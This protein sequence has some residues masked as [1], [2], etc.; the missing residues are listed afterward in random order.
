MQISLYIMLILPL[1]N[2]ISNLIFCNKKK[3]DIS[4]LVYQASSF[5]ILISSI[6]LLFYNK[7]FIL[8]FNL[9]NSLSASFG[10]TGIGKLFISLTSFIFLYSLNTLESC[11]YPWN[12]TVHQYHQ[13]NHLITTQLTISLP[14]DL[15]KTIGYFTTKTTIFLQP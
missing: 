12:K 5:L 6:S 3:N 1:L 7:E 4:V 15:I 10:L 14:S 8:T 2:F 13:I 11:F 9:V